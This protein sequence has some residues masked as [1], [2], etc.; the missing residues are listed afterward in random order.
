MAHALCHLWRLW[1]AGR[2]MARHDALSAEQAASLPWPARCAYG[3]ARFGTHRP[4]GTG[5]LTAALYD[6]GPSYIKLGQF[7]ATRPD[8]VGKA[9]ADELRALQDKLAPFG[10]EQ[11]PPMGETSHGAEG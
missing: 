9:R 11:A 4:R 2:T 8:I 7:L 10:I 3:L 5:Q 6:L 1:R